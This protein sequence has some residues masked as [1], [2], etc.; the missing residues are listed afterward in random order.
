MTAA[1]RA[2]SLIA[3]VAAL[4]GCLPDDTRTAPGHLAVTVTSDY[5]LGSGTPGIDTMDGWHIEYDRFLVTLGEVA[6][7]GDDCTAYNETDYARVIDARL[8]TSQKLSTPVALGSCDFRFRMRP[9]PE[10]A[11]LGAGVSAADLTFLRMPDSDGFAN[12]SG[13]AV[14]VAGKAEKADQTKTFAWAF[15]LGA[16]YDH[17][18]LLA[19]SGVRLASGDQKSVDIAIRSGVLF[20]NVPNDLLAEL[21][22]APFADADD[23]H[24]DADGDVSLAELALVPLAAN[25]SFDRWDNFADYLYTGLVPKLPRFRGAGICNVGPIDEGGDGPG[26]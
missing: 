19:E 14:Y 20:Q 17:C 13:S 6:L 23:V 1:A 9:P 7:R 8:G 12:D 10:D 15:R 11:V 24:G 22:F 26:G 4:T 16:Q 25:A 3:G 21:R 5:S 18:K 2:L